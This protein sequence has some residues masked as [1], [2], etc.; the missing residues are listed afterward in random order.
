MKKFWSILMV[1]SVL[2]LG[3]A[4]PSKQSTGG[5]ASIG[6][7]PTQMG[8]TVNPA[9]AP[10]VSQ[11]TPPDVPAAFLPPTASLN[12]PDNPNST[13]TQNVD[14]EYE[15]IVVLSTDTVKETVTAYPDG[16]SVTV[17]EPQPAGTTLK[18]KA[19]SNV[20]QELGGSWYDK[21][22]ELAASLGSFKAVQGLGAIFLLAGAVSFFNVK[23]RAI[24]GGKDTA[25][26]AGATGLVMIFGPYIL[27]QYSD[28]FFLAIL[29]FGLYWLISRLKYK[30]GLLD[31]KSSPQ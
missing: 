6:H 14:Y 18:R 27:V 30:E 23:L 19:K 21:A 28:Y 31:S 20:N 16:R 1:S 11:Q 24:V 17:R 5:S 4:W 22:K 29:A 25:M 13:S 8:A 15:E 3:C 2:L 7:Q 26:A 12:Q 9:P 10:T